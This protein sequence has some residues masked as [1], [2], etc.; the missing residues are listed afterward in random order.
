MDAVARYVFMLREDSHTKYTLKRDGVLLNV[1][2]QMNK[3]S[4]F[5]ANIISYYSGVQAKSLGIS[6]R[7]A[8][9]Q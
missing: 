1:I 2:E 3:E 4:E 7:G 8:I 6:F 5:E 9:H